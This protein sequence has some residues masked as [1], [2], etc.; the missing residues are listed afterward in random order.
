M[1]QLMFL[2][3]KPYMVEGNLRDQ[4]RYPNT[5][6]SVSDEQIREIVDKVNLADVFERV[7]NDLDR[8]VDWT[9]V[10]SLGEQQRVAFARLIL[11]KP[12]FAFLDE[13]TSALDEDNQDL[14]YRL[15]KDS[16]I[17]YISV[18]HR[19]TLVKHHERLL[20]LNRSGSWELKRSDEAEIK[21]K[22]V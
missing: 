10:L 17:G 19:T 9:N 22:K 18:G 14:L 12:R 3:Q 20:I 4:L 8:V 7:D 5:D 2:P 15:L 6:Q 11:R 16:G 1:N 13:S 21:D